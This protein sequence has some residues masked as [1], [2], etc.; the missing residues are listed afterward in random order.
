[1]NTSKAKTV[2][3]PGCPHRNGDFR[4]RRPA[5][6]EDLPLNRVE[7]PGPGVRPVL[8]RHAISAH[9]E[10]LLVTTPQGWAADHICVHRPFV[11]GG[12]W[13]EPRGLAR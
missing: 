3:L 7:Q 5:P 13:S 2:P 4:R 6:L 11:F 8:R 10:P 9:A 12:G 1:M